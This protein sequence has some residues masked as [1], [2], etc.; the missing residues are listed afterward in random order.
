MKA[1]TKS[2]RISLA[3]LIRNNPMMAEVRMA[4]AR[5]VGGRGWS[6]GQI[7]AAAICVMLY[8]YFLV[9]VV[10]NSG[11]I[12]V[13][14]LFLTMLVI[15]M[16]ILPIAL[17]GVIAGEREK[18]SLEMLLAA[19]V[20][21][22]QIAMAKLM[23]AALFVAVVTVAFLIP[24][25][26]VL[27]VQS[28]KGEINGFPNMGVAFMAVGMS[29]VIT[30]FAALTNA[31]ISLAVS[32]AAKST[33]AA[34]IANI[35]VHFFLLIF[36]PILFTPVAAISGDMASYLMLPHPIWAMSAFLYTNGQPMLNINS[37]Y[38]LVGI[39]IWL[40]ISVFCFIF[41]VNSLDSDRRLGGRRK[42]KES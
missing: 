42:V 10:Q 21:S 36:V 35:G 39:P 29:L 5:F 23:R 24:I 38:G 3:G 12:E 7:A 20:T 14:Y 41:V 25:L 1:T 8:L 15:M 37:L 40:A 34:M 13:S 33:S 9:M 32:A 27:V 18:R 30:F 22:T 28:V 19:P 6:A 16:V 4:N 26:T 17:H 11:S 31:A 2:S